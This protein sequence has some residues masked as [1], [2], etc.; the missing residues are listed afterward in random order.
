MSVT[1]TSIDI[2]GTR[3]SPTTIAAGA[4]STSSGAD[5]STYVGL[6]ISMVIAFASAPDGAVKIELQTSPDNT[7]W[8]TIAFTY[9]EIPYEILTTITKSIPVR[10]EIKYLRV[11][12]TNED[13]AAN[14]TAYVFAVGTG[15]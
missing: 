7:N 6:M 4:S 10:A 5:L 14:I 3:A 11:K 1:K 13:S 12:V 2:L 15:V 9:G 8:D